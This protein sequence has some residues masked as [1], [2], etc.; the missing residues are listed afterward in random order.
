MIKYVLT[1]Y[2]PGFNFWGVE[3]TTM[4]FGGCLLCLSIA[5]HPYGLGEKI[6]LIV[7]L[8]KMLLKVAVS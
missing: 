6:K 4:G 7:T 1:K 8:A 3:S 2:V 5:V